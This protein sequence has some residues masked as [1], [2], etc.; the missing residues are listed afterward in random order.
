MN[1]EVAESIWDGE[2]KMIRSCWTGNG[3]G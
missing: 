2:G 3:A 1:P